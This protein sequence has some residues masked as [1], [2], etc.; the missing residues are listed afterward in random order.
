MRKRAEMC[1]CGQKS[2]T[3][4]LDK[5]NTLQQQMD[6]SGFVCILT[7]EC[8]TIWLC[9]ECFANVQVLARQIFDIVKNK[10]IHFPG[11]LKEK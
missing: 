7:S 6:A 9:R 11:L 2:K 5:A 1:P 4:D 8:G 10:N 3:Y